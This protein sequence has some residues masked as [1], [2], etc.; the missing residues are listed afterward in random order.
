MEIIAAVRHVSPSPPS[1]PAPSARQPHTRNESSVHSIPPFS[2]LI[3]EIPS[4]F[5]Q[6][7]LLLVNKFS[8][9]TDFDL[10]AHQGLFF[11]EGL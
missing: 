5:L 9:S 3:A 2:L 11:S 7:A 4:V 8:L 10:A 1:S 6:V